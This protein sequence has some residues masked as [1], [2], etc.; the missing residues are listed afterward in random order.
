MVVA[1]GLGRRC[2]LWLLLLLLLRY[3]HSLSRSLFLSLP[4][5]LYVLAITIISSTPFR[6]SNILI[7][8]LYIP[9]Y[10][11]I[12]ERPR[13]SL[14]TRRLT[15]HT[16]ARLAASSSRLFPIPSPLFTPRT[17]HSANYPKALRQSPTFY[18][19][20]PLLICNSGLVGIVSSNRDYMSSFA[21][22]PSPTSPSSAPPPS[23]IHPLCHAIQPQ[24]TC[25]S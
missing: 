3:C 1:A 20:Q 10:N 7:S 9:T 5:L 14:F 15:F 18:L 13:A 4:H 2:L 16:S 6:Y 19:A 22:V 11:R 24:S 12:I 21:T 23:H 17:S 25:R 8:S